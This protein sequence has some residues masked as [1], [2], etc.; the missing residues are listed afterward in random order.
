VYSPMGALGRN[1]ISKDQETEPL[2]RDCMM[3]QTVAGTPRRR[4]D[5]RWNR[6]ATVV[7]REYITNMAIRESAANFKVK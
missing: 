6:A 4:K 3:R 1:H 7:F 2:R 5:E